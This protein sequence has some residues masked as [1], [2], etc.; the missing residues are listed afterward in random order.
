MR[1]LDNAVVMRI[2]FLETMGNP[3]FSDAVTRMSVE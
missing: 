1:R 2:D 3:S